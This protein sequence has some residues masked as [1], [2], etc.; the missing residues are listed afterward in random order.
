MLRARLQAAAAVPLRR[1]HRHRRHA[2]RDPRHHRAGGRA[3]QRRRR[4]RD[5][6]RQV[7]RQEPGLQ[8]RAEP[9]SAAPGAER[10]RSTSIAAR[11]WSTPFGLYADTYR[12]QL[13][14]GAD[15]GLV[16]L[17]ASYGPALLDR[18]ILD[19]LGRARRPVVR[20]DDRGATLRASTST[21]AD[22]RPRRLRPAALPGRPAARAAT[23][24]CATRSGWSIR[25]WRPTRSPASASTTA[26]RRRWRRSSATT[27][28]ATTS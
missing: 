5:P 7:V 28:A 18:A 20:R 16:P 1:H 24:P 17:V 15:L 11:G 2:G 19:A 9:R 21:R 8:R 12:D 23:S 13:A 25:S 27:A 4:R 6:G 26:C 3:H 22:A 10:L 14:R